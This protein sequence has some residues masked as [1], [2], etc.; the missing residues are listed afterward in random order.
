MKPNFALLALLALVLLAALCSTGCDNDDVVGA[1]GSN[2]I[3]T[4]A[5]SAN[6]SANH[7]TG[8]TLPA[9]CGNGCLDEAIDAIK[10]LGQ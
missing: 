8:I 6:D 9:P 1:Y 5:H 4:S 3:G 10:K 2:P 7:P